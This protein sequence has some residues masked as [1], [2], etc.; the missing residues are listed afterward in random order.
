MRRYQNTPPDRA[1]IEN[2]DERRETPQV[3]GMRKS[4]Y[5]HAHGEVVLDA[6]R[7]TVMC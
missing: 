6:R 4:G 3:Q 5:L 1:S 2:P 7:D